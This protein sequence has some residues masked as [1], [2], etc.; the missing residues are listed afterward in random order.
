MRQN[1]AGL[2]VR[3]MGRHERDFF[4]C[5][6]ALNLSNGANAMHESTFWSYDIRPPAPTHILFSTAF[7]SVHQAGRR[8]GR[9]VLSRGAGGGKPE[10]RIT[11]SSSKMKSIQVTPVQSPISAASPGWKMTTDGLN[12]WNSESYLRSPSPLAQ[13]P[14]RT[15]SKSPEKSSKTQEKQVEGNRLQSLPKGIYQE[16]PLGEPLAH[17]HWRKTTYLQ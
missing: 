4:D 12:E 3:S 11:T 6:I 2:W 7:Y 9:G 1:G 10:Q 14:A 13:T 16:I 17:R 8:N 5:F 15:P